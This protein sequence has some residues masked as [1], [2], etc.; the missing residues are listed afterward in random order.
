[1]VKLLD[2]TTKTVDD[3][4]C[5]VCNKKFNAARRCNYTIGTHHITCPNCGVKL[6]VYTSVE[7]HVHFLEK[8]EE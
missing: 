7:Y 1:M 6:E 3:G 8:G 5:P 4:L 2:G